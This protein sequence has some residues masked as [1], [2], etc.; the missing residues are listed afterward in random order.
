[1]VAQNLEIDITARDDASAKLAAVR[2]KFAAEAQSADKRQYSANGQPSTPADGAPSLTSPMAR[3]E[4]IRKNFAKSADTS[5]LD[6]RIFAATHTARERELAAVQAHSKKLQDRYKSDADMRAKIKEAERKQIEA[7]EAKYDAQ[8]ER[9]G[10]KGYMAQNTKIGAAVRGVMAGVA[11]A[12]GVSTAYNVAKAYYGGKGAQTAEEGA[13]A[14]VDSKAAWS[15]AIADI[16]LVGAIFGKAIDE[17]TD[18][19]GAE[20]FLERVKETNKAF[21]DLGK[22]LNAAGTSATQARGKA[23]GYTAVDTGREELSAK[24]SVYAGT[25]AAARETDFKA[26]ND[27]AAAMQKG[28]TGQPLDE[29][30]H[31]AEQAEAYLR[32]L[33]RVI[34]QERQYAELSAQH[35]AQ[36]ER[37]QFGRSMDA[38]KVSAYQMLLGPSIEARQHYE[39]QSLETK[40][41]ADQDQFIGLE[42]RKTA[43]TNRDQWIKDWT[44]R[45]EAK[46]SRPD[47]TEV[48]RI[49]MLR[50]I[51]RGQAGAYDA[52]QKRVAELEGRRGELDKTQQLE[53]GAQTQ[54]HQWE[55]QDYAAELG[56][57]TFKA[58]N[59]GDT[60]AERNRVAQA[61]LAEKHRQELSRIDPR[62]DEYK[63][64]QQVQALEK[65]ALI[66]NQERDIAKQR[67]QW[68]QDA[69]MTEAQMSRSYLAIRHAELKTLQEQYDEERRLNGD[70]AELVA[71]YKAKRDAVET[72]FDRNREDEATATDQSILRAAGRNVNADLLGIKDRYAKLREAAAGDKV[73]LAQ[74]NTAEKAETIRVQRDNAINNRVPFETQAYTARFL[75]GGQNRNYSLDQLQEQKAGNKWLQEIAKAIAA[76]QG[77]QVKTVSMQ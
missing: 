27:Y 61:D 25:L 23:F 2:Q 19:A 76:Q 47:M 75:M 1:M 12:E 54:Q 69:T 71:K 45:E 22:T 40:H 10:L 32:T 66:D 56:A 20:K 37:N 60:V 29:F 39:R 68:R 11:V 6:K 24:E 72:N 48:E 18:K 8:E 42:E 34:E 36:A 49:R 63:E 13:Q 5:D 28:I 21:A 7:I 17:F 65:Q 26:R 46:R 77:V 16:P 31:K 44:A 52:E 33:Q 50:D 15:A 73:R 38:R 58:K 55:R 9:K 67:K 53:K 57:R 59:A 62:L 51:R 3:L 35:A 30:K 4:D 64:R 74:L 70:S 14:I 43:L 41:S